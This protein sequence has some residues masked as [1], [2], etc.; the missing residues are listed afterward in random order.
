MHGNFQVCFV[1]VCVRRKFGVSGRLLNV[2]GNTVCRMRRPVP[3]HPRLEATASHRGAFSGSLVFNPVLLC[4]LPACRHS[5][6]PSGPVFPGGHQETAPGAKVT[7]LQTAACCVCVRVPM[8]GCVCAFTRVQSMALCP[9]L[10]GLY[11]ASYL[12]AAP[13]AR[14]G[15]HLGGVT[16][17]V[18]VALFHDTPQGFVARSA[19]RR[20]AD[21]RQK[22]SGE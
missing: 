15:P 16:S 14:R 18:K 8:C 9:L 19:S 11:I 17:P 5:G 22:T 21:S 1:C 6:C 7:R 12:L 2:W 20:G 10:R 3:A 4:H 13:L